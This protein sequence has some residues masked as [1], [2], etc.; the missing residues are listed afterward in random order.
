MLLACFGTATSICKYSIN[1]TSAN[2]LPFSGVLHPA[3]VWS[4]LTSKSDFFVVSVDVT[5]DNVHHS[6]QSGL[7]SAIKPRLLAHHLSQDF[8]DKLSEKKKKIMF[9]FVDNEKLLK[10]TYLH[11]AAFVSMSLSSH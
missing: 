10:I 11:F 5:D 9:C 4:H 3:E 6:F 1:L 8:G 7:A 2:M